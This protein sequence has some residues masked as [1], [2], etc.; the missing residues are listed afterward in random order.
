MECGLTLFSGLCQD[1]AMEC[2]LSSFL[3]GLLCMMGL[4]LVLYRALW[5]AKQSVEAQKQALEKELY[6]LQ[7]LRE[8]D[9][10][11]IREKEEL[12]AANNSRLAELFKSLSAEALA[13][14]NQSFFALAKHSFEHFQASS[15]QDFE[16]NQGSI[17]E[18]LKPLQE[19][20]GQLQGHIDQLEKSR[21]GAYAG[22]S[23]Q[24][25][26]LLA[27][28]VKLEAETHNLVKALRAPQVRGQ[29]GEMHLR[30]AVELAGMLSH[31]DFVEQ[32]SFDTEEGRQRPDMVV[33]LPSGR[34]IIVDA[35]TPLAS[36]LEAIQC[37][38][39]EQMRVHFQSHARHLR[40]HVTKLSSKQYWKQL[41]GSPEFVVLFIPGESFFSA[42]LEQDPSLIELGA[43]QKV[44]LATP[45]TL[46]ALLKT[47]AYGWQQEA[48]NQESRAI[49]RLGEELYERISIFGDHFNELR[50]GIEKT[51]QAYNKSLVSMESR[52]LPVARKFNQLHIKASKPVPDTASL[53]LIPVEPRALELQGKACF[54]AQ[55]N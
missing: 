25:K 11:K 42:A 15:R 22:L 36:Y 19:K 41:E 34:S 54:H 43:G 52:L 16:R 40:D 35:K 3:I 10:L 2:S 24:V 18:V 37:Q 38:E 27:S 26:Y 31:V 17:Q 14:N 51:V 21:L 7:A 29:W 50:K 46:I 33:K 44:L 53:D 28:Q 55:G 30:R 6:A 13:Q 4:A 39:P 12:L 45:T 20:L 8:Q 1:G 9:L 48:L 5:K 49:S 23:E 47:V 32:S